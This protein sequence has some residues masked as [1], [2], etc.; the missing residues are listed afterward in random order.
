MIL[1]RKL[2]KLNSPEPVGKW[3]SFFLF[4]IL[5]F[6]FYHP[7]IDAKFTSDFYS[8]IGTYDEMGKSGLIKGFGDPGFHPVY[9]T[10][11]YLLYRLFDLNSYLWHFVFV[12]LHCLNA[13]LI[14]RVFNS[15]FRLIKLDKLASVPFWAALFYLLSPY[16]TE[17][18]VWGATIHYLLC[19]CFM[20]LSFYS[21]VNW[22][23]A[24]NQTFV[25]AGLS[26]LFFALA[27]CSLEMALV[28]PFALIVFIILV[29]S[30]SF[31]WDKISRSLVS[32]S[33]P[34]LIVIFL[35]FLN[36]KMLYGKWVGH[37]GAS[38]H[39]N[40]DIN[41]LAETFG[42]YLLK[43]LFFPRYILDANEI[44]FLKIFYHKYFFL[45]L[46][47]IGLGLT[48]SAFVF[49]LKKKNITFNFIV[50][51]LIT[52]VFLLFPVIN[53]T[54]AFSYGIHSDRYGYFASVFFYLILVSVVTIVFRKMKFFPLIAILLFM[55]SLLFKTNLDWK[56]TGKLSWSLIE[57]YD[58]MDVENVYVLNLPDNYKGAYLYRNGFREALEKKY[59][60]PIAGKI[61]KANW[62][63]MVS[64]NQCPKVERVGNNKITSTFIESGSWWWYYGAGASSYDKEKY[65]AQFNGASFE[66]ILKDYD[67][68]N[69]VVI[70][71]CDGKWLELEM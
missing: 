22:F 4:F 36:N 19:L 31:P 26:V 11:T 38:T 62:Y 7:T 30:K 71:A 68:S 70:Y 66:L 21:L 64:P 35:Y 34:Q 9:H 55:A 28:F 59:D 42:K 49:A 40:F 65:K 63:N 13:W 37:Y 33:L 5:G 60:K 39:L 47:I 43:F 54:T 44:G 69:S 24:K 67:S 18:V 3:A 20:L 23:A 52:Y 61:Y 53:L 2:E 8:W 14:Y 10:S 50:A 46:M 57:T 27:L 17:A 56:E 32:I 15:F 6:I 1:F 45:V 58:W 51:S 41:V 48:I 16:Q 12:F 25:F 29:F